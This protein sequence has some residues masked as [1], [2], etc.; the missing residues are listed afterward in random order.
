MTELLHKEYNESNDVKKQDDSK[1][2][3]TNDSIAMSI[4][5]E[6]ETPVPEQDFRK[7]L[8]VIFANRNY[9]VLITTSWVYSTFNFLSSYFNLYLRSL[10]WEVFVI[11][12]V[13]SFSAIISAFTRLIGGY[14]G[15]VAN[16][17]RI[18]VYA[19]LVYAIYY[20]IIGLVADFWLVIAAILFLSIQD[21]FRS[22]SS[23]FF[24][25]NVPKKESGLALS[26]F[27]AGRGFSIVSLIAFGFLEPV[28]GFPETFRLLYFIAGFFVLLSS[29]ARA[30]LL[31]PVDTIREKHDKPIVREFFSQNVRA[32]KLLVA[33][34]PGLLSIVIIDTISD[35]FFKTV[36]LIY[37]NEVLEINF[38]GINLMLIFQLILVVPLVL[39]MGRIS[40]RKGV[41]N[42]AIVVYGVMPIS[43]GM[44]F[45]APII[46]YIAPIEFVL[47]I[48][49]LVPG[50]GVIL[51]MPFIAIVMKYV[52]DTLW[53]ALII[54]LIRKRLPKTDTAKILSIFWVIVYVMSSIGPA[55]AGS[56]YSFLD[57][58][59]TFL[60][61]LILNIFIL[62]SI[63]LG[64]FGNGNSDSI[65]SDIEEQN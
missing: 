26:L 5:E 51:T 57:P 54:I 37:T 56:I 65:P 8:R 4:S 33:A 31:D 15:D 63:A 23:A 34:I 62:I 59:M 45:I 25:E 48:D 49:S 38:A 18:A 47:M 21:L 44:L 46:P 29:A 13:L 60:I 40:D 55:L 30:Y 36:A 19:Q 52:N 61:I 39:K 27:T 28:I 64:P 11:G 41:K 16:R 20:I 17:K 35:S 58:Q 3:L 2:R 12:V 43:A 1:D 32:A 14:Y 53:W 24:M 50:L 7:S 9:T 22:G 6:G 42:A 10:G